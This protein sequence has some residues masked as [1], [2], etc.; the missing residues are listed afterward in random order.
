MQ[1]SNFLKEVAWAALSCFP[2]IKAYGSK[3]LFSWPLA[4][5]RTI[6]PLKNT[7]RLVLLVAFY[8]SSINYTL[9]FKCLPFSIISSFAELI[10]VELSL[11]SSLKQLG[12]K[13]ACFW[14]YPNRPLQTYMF[15]KKKERGLD[16]GKEGQE[17]KRDG[18]K[19]YSQ[20]WLGVNRR[21]QELE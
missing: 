2:T 16:T 7:L 12:V 20:A 19:Q 1:Q 9:F 21:W 13:R 5:F 3:A 8:R 6:L 14:N 10:L 18:E 4:W 15:N 17:G 11:S